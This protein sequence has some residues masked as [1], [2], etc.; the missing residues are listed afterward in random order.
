MPEIHCVQ[1]E[2][3]IH[4]SEKTDYIYQKNTTPYHFTSD[5]PRL[6]RALSRCHLKTQDSEDLL[7]RLLH[8]AHTETPRLCIAKMNAWQPR[9]WNAKTRTRELCFLWQNATQTDPKRHV[10]SNFVLGVWNNVQMTTTTFIN[11]NS[12]VQFK[13]TPKIHARWNLD[14]CSRAHT[15]TCIA[16]CRKIRTAQ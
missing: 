7:R 14:S 16:R 2:H 5:S 3:H 12:I 13:G 1:Y 15:L 10:K 11:I 4:A 9:T 6:K 8:M